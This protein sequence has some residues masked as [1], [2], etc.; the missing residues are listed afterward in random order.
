MS[1]MSGRPGPL[2]S[3][4]YFRSGRLIV[5]WARSNHGLTPIELLIVLAVIGVLG[6]SGCFCTPNFTEQARIA[7]AE[8]DIVGPLVGRPCPYCTNRSPC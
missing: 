1:C 8:A 7:R 2:G 6:L 5:R 4:H 3:A